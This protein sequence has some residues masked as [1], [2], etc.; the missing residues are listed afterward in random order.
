KSE[1]SHLNG[2]YTNFGVVT[3]GMDVVNKMAI[4]DKILG[5]T[6]E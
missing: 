5:I 1:A 6:I 4:G 2:K 3:K